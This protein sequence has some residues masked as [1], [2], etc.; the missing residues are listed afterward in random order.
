M[1]RRG[2]IVE[3]LGKN[4]EFHFLIY[5]ASQ[6][7]VLIQLIETLWLRF[8]PY[9]RTLTLHVEPILKSEHGETY[10]VHHHEAIA[11]LKA[12][13]AAQVRQAIIA[14]ILTTQELLRGLCA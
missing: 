9:M 2:S 14:D 1:A 4:H 5:R 12:G 13:D 8:G 10:T 11:G 3:M 6:S 7:D